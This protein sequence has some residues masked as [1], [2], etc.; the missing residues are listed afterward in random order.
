ML[1]INFK[2]PVCDAVELIQLPQEVSSGVP[3][4]FSAFRFHNT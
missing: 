4:W 1:L 2:L 3:L